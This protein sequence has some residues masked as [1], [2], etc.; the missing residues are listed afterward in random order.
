MTNIPASLD[1]HTLTQRYGLLCRALQSSPENAQARS[2]NEI[3]ARLEALIHRELLTL[4]RLGSP[5]DF[6]EIYLDFSR[7]LTRFREFCT[8]PRLAQKTIVAFG[9]PFSAGKSS[10]I[11]ALLGHKLLVV[12]VDPTT[13]LP[14]Y[15]FYDA[16]DGISALNLHHQRIP[17]EDDELASLTHEEPQ[18]YGSQV[19]RALSAAFISRRDFPWAN[20][21]LIDTP[22]YTGQAAMGERTDADLATAQLN[23]AHAIVWVV[24]IK[25]G[26][27]SEEDLRFIARLDPA[28]PR[29]VVAS[30]ADQLPEDERTRVIERM[31]AT[32]A[33]RNLP[34]EGVYA[35]SARPRYAELLQPLR[36]QLDAW[37]ATARQQ[38]FTHRF[39]AFF[40]RYQR[41]LERE[42]RLA[43]WMRHRL[44][45]LVTLAENELLQDIN[46][47]LHA[48]DERLASLKAVQNHLAELRTR[49]FGELK[50]AGQIVGI[51]LPEPHEL[52]LLEPG[53]SN[54]LEQLIA[55]RQQQGKEEPDQRMALKTLMQPGMAS[56]RAWL[57]RRSGRAPLAKACHVL[58]L[59]GEPRQRQSLLRRE[60]AS[61]QALAALTR[62]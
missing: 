26:D 56:Q 6:A 61:Q 32:L 8:E 29:I 9:G 15:L 49:F 13:A 60:R 50:R 58:R 4:A 33:Q 23:G 62:S 28:I 18:R 59:A 7:E 53:Q 55:L 31:R 39:K 10:L 44:S 41:G 57:I 1:T 42:Q 19:A 30:H 24:S 20:L 52:D 36:A 27:L 34:V 37:N 46:E 54:L 17:L 3:V 16:H 43:Q 45:R 40:T 12:E 51:P 14:A 2:V 5:D 47:L 35:V 11:N 38:R 48:H 25:Q 22:G 21:A